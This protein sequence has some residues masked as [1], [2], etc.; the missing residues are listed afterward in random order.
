MTI[1]TKENVGSFPEGKKSLSNGPR[2]DSNPHRKAAALVGLVQL[3]EKRKKE[4]W[5][6][7]KG[8]T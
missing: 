7:E 6:M 2:E 4:K 3:G 8:T 5:Q 1:E